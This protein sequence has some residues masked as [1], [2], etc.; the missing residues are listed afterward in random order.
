MSRQERLSRIKRQIRMGI[1]ESDDKWRITIAGLAA[2][3]TSPMLNQPTDCGGHEAAARLRLAAPSAGRACL[4][5]I[6][7]P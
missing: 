1:Y 2:D 4:L 3:T 6:P 5:R 7:A